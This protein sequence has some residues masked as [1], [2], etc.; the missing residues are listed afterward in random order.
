MCWSLNTN[1]AEELMAD[2]Y[3]VVRHPLPPKHNLSK[4][5]CKVLEQLKTDKDPII[6]MADKGLA[7]VVMDRQ[8][9]I[10]KARVL[11]EDINT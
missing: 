11:L 4:E 10:K 9:Y 2:I 3:R 5:E 7:P 8:N 6:L 1:E